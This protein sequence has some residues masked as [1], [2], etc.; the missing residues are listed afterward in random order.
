M[1][2]AEHG[3][4]PILLSRTWHGRETCTRFRKLAPRTAPAPSL[5]EYGTR[6]PIL[7]RTWGRAAGGI[8]E[9]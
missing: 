6:C 7:S 2:L 9:R 4:G 8:R 3:I 5:A 1:S